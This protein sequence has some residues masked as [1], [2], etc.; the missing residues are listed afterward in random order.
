MV[1]CFLRIIIKFPRSSSLHEC[2]IMSLKQRK[3]NNF[4]KE[5]TAI[6]LF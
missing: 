6:K 5:K 1:K 3:I 4:V 2:T